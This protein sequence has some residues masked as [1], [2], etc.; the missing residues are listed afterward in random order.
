MKRHEI[1]L[2]SERHSFAGP[3]TLLRQ[4]ISR[5]QHDEY[6]HMKAENHRHWMFSLPI[7]ELFIS[8]QKQRLC[9]WFVCV[10]V[11]EYIL[12]FVQEVEESQNQ[13]QREDGWCCSASSSRMFFSFLVRICTNL[14]LWDFMFYAREPLK[15]TLIENRGKSPE[16]EK[17]RSCE[18]WMN[19]GGKSLPSRGVRV[20]SEI[21][22]RF[23]SI[24]KN[25]DEERNQYQFTI[26]GHIFCTEKETATIVTLLALSMF[27]SCL[28]ISLCFIP[29]SKPPARVCV[30]MEDVCAT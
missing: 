16:N 10:C 18:R 15:E 1:N 4:Q 22:Y 25:N 27:S 26:C 7:L 14:V 5:F 3:P 13:R 20:L 11:R 23:P 8:L 9:D 19:L 21:F 24:D 17:C 30:L 6:V 12:Y 29:P 28:E 2:P